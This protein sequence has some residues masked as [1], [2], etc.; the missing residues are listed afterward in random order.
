[1]RLVSVSL[2]LTLQTRMDESQKIRKQVQEDQKAEKRR[3]QAEA[4]AKAAE[5]AREAMKALEKQKVL[6]GILTPTPSPH[7][8]WHPPMC[9][10]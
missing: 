5:V 7:S 9:C 3:K 1:M 6:T 4:A 8:L 2:P 10:A